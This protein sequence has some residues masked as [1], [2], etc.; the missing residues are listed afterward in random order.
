MANNKLVANVEGEASA[1]QAG[2]PRKCRNQGNANWLTKQ[3]LE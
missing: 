1:S 3:T 2:P